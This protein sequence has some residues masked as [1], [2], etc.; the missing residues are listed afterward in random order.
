VQTYVAVCIGEGFEICNSL[1]EEQ[2]FEK[3]ILYADF[4]GEFTHAAKH[5]GGTQWSS[6][7]G[8]YIDIEHTL[9]SLEGSYGTI[10]A[11]LRRAIQPASAEEA[12]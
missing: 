8:E 5:V 11:I 10:A 12:T 3:I 7:I 6:K 2:G 1:D 4:G 9:E